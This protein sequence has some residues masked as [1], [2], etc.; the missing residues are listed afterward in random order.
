MTGLRIT[1]FA[2]DRVEAIV[3]AQ[4][5]L[6]RTDWCILDTETTGVNVATAQIVQ[7][8]V[9]APSGRVLLDTLVRPPVRIPASATA[10]HGIDDA[11]VGSAPGFAD[12][13]PRLVEAVCGRWVI[14]YNRA[15]DFGLLSRLGRAAG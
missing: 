9:L 13:Y 6:A 10:I 4:A 12:V 3:W 2:T 8:G 14:I 5:L 7:I 15:Y 1:D 11:A